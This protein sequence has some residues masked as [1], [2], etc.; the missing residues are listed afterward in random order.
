MFLDDIK[1]AYDHNPALPSLL[2][3][4]DFAKEQ[5]ARDAAWRRVVVLAVANGVPVPGLTASLSY[6]DTYR[7]CVQGLRHP[8]IRSDFRFLA[9]LIQ[10][11]KLRMLTQQPKLR[12][13]SRAG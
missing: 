12:H 3:D 4:P 2:V 1:R 11:P 6:F 10:Q 8:L 7:R 5:A 9:I 13:V